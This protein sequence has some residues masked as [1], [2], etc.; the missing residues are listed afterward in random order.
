VV[1][2]PVALQITARDILALADL[3]KEARPESLARVMTMTSSSSPMSHAFASAGR[4]SR[5]RPV[6]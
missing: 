2:V 5:S 3:L 6:R 1:G 4:A